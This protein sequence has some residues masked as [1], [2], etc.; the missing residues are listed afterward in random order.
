MGG[1]GSGRPPNRESLRPKGKVQKAKK[2]NKTSVKG[3][4]RSLQ[5][6]LKKVQ[7]EVG[8]SSIFRSYFAQSCA[9]ENKKSLAAFIL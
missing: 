3:Q 6:L 5:R 2:K 4:L 9:N 1:P 8:S 7:F